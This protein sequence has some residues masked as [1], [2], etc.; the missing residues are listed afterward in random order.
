MDLNV[1]ALQSLEIP[2]DTKSPKNNKSK[3]P[4]N[5]SKFKSPAK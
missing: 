4:I 1:N 5:K 2:N 3:S